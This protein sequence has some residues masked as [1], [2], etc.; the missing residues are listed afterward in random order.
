REGRQILAE[1]K[2][3]LRRHMKRRGACAAPAATPRGGHVNPTRGVG[4]SS[5]WGW[6]PSASG[7]KTKPVALSLRASEGFAPNNA[8]FFAGSASSALSWL[9]RGV[10]G[11]ALSHVRVG[12]LHRPR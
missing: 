5:R 4:V 1:V 8:F 2:E 9:E 6:G 12:L 11:F 10:L 7:K 3:G